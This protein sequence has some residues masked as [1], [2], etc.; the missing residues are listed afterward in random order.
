MSVGCSWNLVE[1]TFGSRNNR[2]SLLTA[3]N[4][5]GSY[6]KRK[7]MRL[8]PHCLYS[9][10]RTMQLFVH[11]RHWSVEKLLAKSQQFYQD[12]KCLTVITLW[13]RCCV[14]NRKVAGSIPDGVIGIFNWHNPPDRT[15]AL[16][17]TQPLTEMSTRRISWGVNAAG[18]YGWQTYHLP[19]SLSWNL[20]T[21]TSWNPLGHPRPVTGLI[22][23]FTV[24]TFI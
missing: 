8:F 20:G 5:I 11:C 14:T 12:I 10:D 21:L 13:L 15:M 24:I 17:S 16:V 7:R 6:R 9:V 18:A 4:L 22:F 2:V 23:F 1:C 3:E 19:V